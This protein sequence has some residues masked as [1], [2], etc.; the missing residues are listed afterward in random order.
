MLLL[1]SCRLLHLHHPASLSTATL[2]LCPPSLPQAL[3]G[4]LF[5]AATPEAP[6]PRVLAL[7]PGVRL[8]SET[9]LEYRCGLWCCLQLA[10]PVCPCMAG[11]GLHC[12]PTPFVGLPARLS[13]TCCRDELL[14]LVRL[15]GRLGRVLLLPDPVCNAT[16]VRQ[17]RWGGW[18][19]DWLPGLC[20]AA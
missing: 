3:R 1:I 20:S 18:A 6:L 11:N 13:A 10:S 4:Q 17:G 9:A 7:L 8:P 16:W 15:A 14:Q 5:P 19:L 12:A 2:W